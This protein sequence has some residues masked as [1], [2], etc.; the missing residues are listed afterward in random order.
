M[1]ERKRRPST[2]GDIIRGHYIEDRGITVTALGRALG[3]SRK[4]MSGIV[5]GHARI[6]P[7]IAARLA[8]VLGTTTALWLNLQAAVDAWDADRMARKW[9]PAAPLPTAAE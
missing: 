7:A 3:V 1:I 4:H 5:N 2:P 6:E 8:K 9:R